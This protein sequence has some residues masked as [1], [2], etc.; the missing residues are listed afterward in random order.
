MKKSEIIEAIEAAAMRAEGEG[1]RHGD[2]QYALCY[3]I[4]WLSRAAGSGDR[5]AIKLRRLITVIV[6][7]K[8]EALAAEKEDERILGVAE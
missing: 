4:G 6:N 7:G 3:L 2:A 1:Y 5:D 8:A